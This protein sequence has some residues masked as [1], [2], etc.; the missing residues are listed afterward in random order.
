MLEN[1]Y[2]KMQNQASIVAKKDSTRKKWLK[3]I[4]INHG[5]GI[6]IG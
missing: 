2:S 4:F 1:S 6:A 3:G 5:S